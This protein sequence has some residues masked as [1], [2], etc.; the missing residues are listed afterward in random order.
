MYSTRRKVKHVKLEMISKAFDPRSHWKPRRIGSF[1][2]RH[3]GSDGGE[4]MEALQQLVS[5]GL[6]T[7]KAMKRE[8]AFVSWYHFTRRRRELK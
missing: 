1:H 4:S 8:H 7:Y 5:G 6:V 2:R 3:R